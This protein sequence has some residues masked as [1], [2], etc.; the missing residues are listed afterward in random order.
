MKKVGHNIFSQ[1][2]GG[3]NPEHPISMRAWSRGHDRYV[4]INDY[5][6][7]VYEFANV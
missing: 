1:G 2:W 6:R 7:N 5:A 3:I 4:I